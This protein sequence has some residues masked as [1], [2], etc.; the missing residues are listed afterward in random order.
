MI[1]VAGPRNDPAS[2]GAPAGVEVRAFVPELYK[3]LAACDLAVVQGGLTTTMELT[4]L[5]KPFVYVP[6][7][8]HFEQNLHVRRRLDRYEAGRHLS[9]EEALDP[10]GLAEAIV[11]E[12]GRDGRYRPVATDGAA[13][14]AAMLADLI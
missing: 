14:A 10:E 13:R 4:A 5:N 2:L 3:H 9:Y 8:H 6:L 1:A 7:R 12:V 11:K